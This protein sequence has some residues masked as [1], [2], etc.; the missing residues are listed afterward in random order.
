[1]WSRV[2]VLRGDRLRW[3]K[4]VLAEWRVSGGGAGGVHWGQV[5]DGCCWRVRI[6]RQLHHWRRLGGGETTNVV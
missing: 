3:A 1:M 5:M 4:Q 2:E 6:R